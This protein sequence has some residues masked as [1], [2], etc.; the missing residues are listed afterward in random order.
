LSSQRVACRTFL[1]GLASRKR[2]LRKPPMR[3]LRPTNNKA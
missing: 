2:H 3:F 1:R